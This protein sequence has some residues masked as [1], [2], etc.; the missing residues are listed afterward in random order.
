M[1]SE[2]ELKHCVE[3]R[4]SGLKRRLWN[5]EIPD[6]YDRSA[7]T[8][9][10]VVQN[11]DESPEWRGVRDHMTLAMQIRSVSAREDARYV[12]VEIEGTRARL[13]FVLFAVR[14]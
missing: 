14:R 4:S 9:Y 5:T 13:R 8:Y 11:E 2:R 10:A 3:A 12:D 6:L 7:W 1:A